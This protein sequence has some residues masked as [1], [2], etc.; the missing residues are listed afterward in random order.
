MKVLQL[1]TWMGKI[2]GALERFLE[3][4]D[5]DVICMR[6]VMAS[7][8]CE[9][10]LSRLCADKSRLKKAAR[11]PYEF[12]SPNWGSEMAGGTMELGNLILSKI[13]LMAQ[14]AVFVNGGYD[15]KTVLGEMSRN[16]LN[17]QVVELANG[18]KV[19]NHHGFWR[20][21]PVGD[22]ETVAVF[23]RVAEVV[24]AEGGPLVFCGDLNV[25]HDSPAMRSLDFLRD[26]TD[27]YKVVTTL[28][29]IKVTRDVPCDHIMVSKDVTVEDF[30]VYSDLVSDH[31]AIA[32]TIG[33]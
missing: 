28:S 4:H 7:P 16:N 30:T 10:H 3:T 12:F 1:N 6:E 20:P 17:V 32:A 23:R 5:F 14:K 33:D 11:L 15:P 27:E 29:G 24:R 18:F 19:V 31:L 21:N 25:I 9:L 8:D 13:P 26:L 22:E 2:E